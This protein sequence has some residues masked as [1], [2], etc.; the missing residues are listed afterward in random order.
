MDDI[1]DDVV[2]AAR[3]CESAAHRFDEEPLL[4]ILK[5]LTTSVQQVGEAW[6]GSYIGYHAS[7][8]TKGLRPRAAGEHFDSEWGSVDAYA[9]R[10]TGQWAEYTYDTVR[11]VILERA[12]TIDLSLITEASDL[13]RTV[14]FEVKAE[15]LPTF[16]ALLADNEDTVLRELRTK[17][18]ELPGFF[19]QQDV[20][21]RFFPQG[22]F[23]SRDSLAMTQGL[24]LPHHLVFTAWLAEQTSFSMQTGQ[25]AKLTRHAEIYL[26][27]KLK[28][29]GKTV[30]KT[31]GKIFIGH[32]R[33]EA[34]RDLKDFIQDR[35]QLPWD[36][37]NREA[38][39]GLSTKERLE[40]M[41]DSASFAFLVM[42]AEDEH[43]DSL[44]HARENVIHEVGLFQGRLGFRRA[45]VLLENGCAEFS[46]LGGLTQI[47]F[48]SGNIREVYEEI[49]RVLEREG[50]LR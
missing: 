34:W 26:K 22:N 50:I 27:K 40:A 18:E 6:S 23:M 9:S 35:L 39:A 24:K 12:Q 29:K 1:L 46:N 14:F 10:T 5:A 30:A 31:D 49:R 11:S 20:A 37:F 33:S 21:S 4:S 19:S 2:R 41:L 25:L 17:I 15:L 42:T 7:I 44:R 48:D 32:G 13:C 38:T 3:R 28:M 36:E 43:A 16:D 47:R 45:I 8:Y